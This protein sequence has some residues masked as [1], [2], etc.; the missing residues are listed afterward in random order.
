MNQS[1]ESIFQILSSERFLTMQG[2]ANEVP[3]FIKTYEVS[4]TPSVFSRVARHSS[5]KSP[6]HA[7]HLLRDC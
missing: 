2:L 6:T 7:R 4:E 1:L 5:S 3:I